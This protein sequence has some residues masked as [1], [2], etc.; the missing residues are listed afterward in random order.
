MCGVLPRIGEPFFIQGMI[1]FRMV[2]EQDSA[3]PA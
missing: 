3:M 2:E 1:R